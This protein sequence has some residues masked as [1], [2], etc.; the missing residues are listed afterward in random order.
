M[1][2][3]FA[4][5]LPDRARVRLAS[6]G[7]EVRSEPKLDGDSLAAR[8]AEWDPEILVVRS[9]KV[10]ARHASAG[11]RLS[12][13]V[14]AGAG[15]NTIDVAACSSRGI[16]VTNCPGKNAVAVAELTMGLLLALDR[17]IP[18]EVADLRAG[19]W[20]KSRYS[21]ANGLKG[22]TLG[23]LGAGDIGRAV[24]RRAA[25]FG[26]KVLAWSRSLTDERAAEWNLVRLA[27]PE[28]VAR[29][30]DVVSVHLALTKETRGLVGESVFHAMK[31]GALFLNTSRAE[32]VDEAA[33]LRALDEKG[34]RAGLDVFSNEP[35]GGEAVF[36][37][38]LAKHPSVYG[39]HHVGA[40]TEE[41]QEAVGDEVCR[42]VEAFR[43]QGLVLN[44]VNS[45]A[46]SAATHRVTVRHLDRVGVLAAV[47]GCLREASINV[48]KMENAIFPGGAALA[49]IEVAAE[50]PPAVVERLN[51]VEN[52]LDV[53]V[54][55]L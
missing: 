30:A 50:P 38:P 3:L 9:T 1:R 26:M 8:L 23:L 31:H 7:F 5:K 24:A 39:T 33:L 20:N 44:G 34:V 48:Q 47:L 49:R 22:R 21:A 53:S 54:V 17:R 35:P 43:D 36:D 4:D 29:R 46:P 42:I 55:A 41:A 27:T 40:S 52:V 14:R 45:E 13:V 51:A 15:V 6:V 10:E 19:R 16:Y 12:L 28:E 2:V 37:H 32:I 11:R 25:G 18:D